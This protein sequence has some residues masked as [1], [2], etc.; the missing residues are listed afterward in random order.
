MP[1][2]AAHYKYLIFLYFTA[3]HLSERT[4]DANTV[5]CRQMY[6][7]FFADFKSL[8]TIGNNAASMHSSYDFDNIERVGLPSESTCT[9][10]GK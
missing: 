6:P 2:K 1:T 8:L 4:I 9:T 10:T 3:G 7:N 5:C